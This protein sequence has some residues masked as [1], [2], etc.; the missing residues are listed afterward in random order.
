SAEIEAVSTAFR[1]LMDEV[2]RQRAELEAVNDASPLGLFRCDAA[3]RLVYAN[4]ACRRLLGFSHD[5]AMIDA[6]LERLHPRDR[7]AVMAGWADAV[8]RGTGHCAE[9]RVTVPGHDERLLVV[10]TAPVRVEGRV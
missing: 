3:G 10:N 9:L 2:V 5:E 1:K 7:E 4:E 8:A 6:W